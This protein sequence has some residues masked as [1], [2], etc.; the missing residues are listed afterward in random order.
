MTGTTGMAGTENNT[1]TDCF[2]CVSPFT[3]NKTPV[4]CSKCNYVC[5]KHCVQD[6]LLTRSDDPHCMNCKTQWNEEFLYTNLNKTFMNQ[7][8]RNHQKACLFETEKSRIPDTM[9]QVQDYQ[10]SRRL[11]D[12]NRAIFQEIQQARYVLSQLENRYNQNRNRINIIATGG[13]SV[14]SSERRKFLHKCPEPE[15]KGFL[16]SSWKCG[17]CDHWACSKCFE[18]LGETKDPNHVCKKE[19]V[20]SAEMIKKETRPC[21]QCA[22]PIFKISGCDQMW[23]TQCNIAYS[24]NTGKIVNGGV[25][26]NPHYFQFMQNGG[27]V[28]NPGDQVCGGV[29]DVWNFR[30]QF[31]TYMNA[32]RRLY[33]ETVNSGFLKFLKNNG[34]GDIVDVYEKYGQ[35]CHVINYMERLRCIGHNTDI[36]DGIRLEVNQGA[37]T[38][39][40]RIKYIVGEID[41]KSFKSI[42]LRRNKKLSKQRRFLQVLELMSAVFIENFN[43]LTNIDKLKIDPKINCVLDLI[44]KEQ[45]LIKSSVDTYKLKPKQIGVLKNYLE[46]SNVYYKRIIECIDRCDYMVDYC[47]KELQKIKKDYNCKFYYINKETYMLRNVVDVTN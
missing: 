44:K 18:A 12:E 15:C 16:S 46:L 47:N 33:E 9:P 17:V 1:N 14:N 25:I 21:P 27:Q 38:T 6:Y 5:C 4:K 13:V 11:I 32:I 2:V 24:W 43:T 7:I 29:P 3:R 35:R 22:V 41:E 37:N 10:E 39:Q 45:Q 28:R 40:E 30:N 26:H 42:V 36:I 20:E 34:L 23:C 31:S 19:N 8:W